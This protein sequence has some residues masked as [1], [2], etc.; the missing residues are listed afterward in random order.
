MSERDDDQTA[1]RDETS[2]ERASENVLE[3]WPTPPP[4]A[5][6]PGEPRDR[7]R[8]VEET[9]VVPADELPGWSAAAID[10]V[11]SSENVGSGW[12]GEDEPERSEDAPSESEADAEDSAAPSARRDDLADGHDA[13]EGTRPPAEPEVADVVDDEVLPADEPDVSDA[14]VVDDTGATGRRLRACP[15]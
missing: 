11:E 13:A 2:L 5:D 8:A 3:G 10:E 7:P 4:L 6:P 1:D 15:R 14:P 9:V 12:T